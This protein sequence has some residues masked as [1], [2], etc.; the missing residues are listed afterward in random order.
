MSNH[1]RQKLTKIIQLI[2]LILLTNTSTIAT[3]GS[4][5]LIPTNLTNIITKLY[6]NTQILC[7]INND[8]I[9]DY[10]FNI[11]NTTKINLPW[12][13]KQGSRIKSTKPIILQQ[14]TYSE[15]NKLNNY[16]EYHICTIPDISSYEKEYF[17]EKGIHHITFLNNTKKTIQTNNT[18]LKQSIP[19]ISMN[20][21]CTDAK[22]K[23]E[24]YTTQNSIIIFQTKQPNY[25]LTTT[26]II[27][28]ITIK[29][30]QIS[31]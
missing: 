19:F 9:I 27:K 28:L 12:N 31:Q 7:D 8:G 17:L 2:I 13:L 23:N 6:N 30:L 1:N 29:I 24:T 15:N 3:T 18:I 25:T 22:L 11:E 4:D 5:F 26:M 16:E 10:K 20:S 14:I 21:Y